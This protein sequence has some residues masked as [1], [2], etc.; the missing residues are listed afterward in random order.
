METETKSDQ[1]D[2][3]DI[4]LDDY[5]SYDHEPSAIDST[6]AASAIKSVMRE[7]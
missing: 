3:D 7:P 4:P 6:V 1:R 5:D 2:D